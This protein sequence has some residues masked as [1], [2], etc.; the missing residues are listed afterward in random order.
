M[1]YY[2]K[3]KYIKVWGSIA[4]V[5]GR[6]QASRAWVTRESMEEDDMVMSR[7][8]NTLGQRDEPMGEEGGCKPE[9]HIR[10]GQGLAEG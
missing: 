3:I 9:E 5:Y 7:Y 2:F 4:Q 8:G 1:E 6:E 10:G